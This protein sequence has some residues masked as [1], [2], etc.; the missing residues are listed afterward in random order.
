MI[1]NTWHGVNNNNNKKNS[2]KDFQ[3]LIFR[4]GQ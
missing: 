1:E 3:D 2:Y 4:N